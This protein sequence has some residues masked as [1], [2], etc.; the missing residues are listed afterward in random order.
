MSVITSFET[1]VVR[2]DAAPGTGPGND[3]R[4]M[5]RMRHG[6]EFVVVRI[7]TDEGIEGVGTSIAA[8]GPAIP[9]AFLNDI[10]AP[11]VLGRRSSDREAIW[12]ELFDLNRRLVF[13]PLYLPGPVDVALWDLAAKEAGLPLYR[14]IGAYRDSMPVY[15]S[16]QFLPGIDD[17]LREAQRYRAIGVNAYKIHP[18]GDWRR[19]IEI[20]EAV[21]AANPDMV[22]MLD[23]AG[24][25]YTLTQ[26]VKVGRALERLDFYWLEEPFDDLYL[27]K[28]QELCRTL[29]ISICATEALVGGPVGVAEFLRAGAADIVRADV[30]WKWGVTGT[31]KTL[32]VAEAF[33]VNCELHTTT[34]GYMDI[35]TLHVACATRNSEYYELFAP[36]EQWQF[37]MLEPFPLDAEGRIHA[38]EGPG[39]GVNIDWDAVDNA[40]VRKQSASL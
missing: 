37:P 36:H 9:Q 12:Q 18:S 17:Y 30:S 21:R 15:A 39:I 16:S 22:L 5:N 7:R 31:L 29:D 24:S 35:A 1:S 25:N 13:F 4:E 11:H 40:T 20:A 19:Q 32:H 6:S 38:P 3:E 8:H 27:S 23:P 33:G 28:Y 10:I 14:Y 34:M 26:A 2:R